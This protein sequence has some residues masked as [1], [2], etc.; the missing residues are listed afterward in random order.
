[1]KDHGVLVPTLNP[2]EATYDVALSLRDAAGLPKDKIYIL[3]SIGQ[4][5]YIG[6]AQDPAGLAT[7]AMNVMNWRNRTQTH[8]YTD[9]YFYG[10]DEKKESALTAQ[11]SA[12]QTVHANGG[13]MFVACSSDALGL[14]GDLLDVAVLYG[15]YSAQ[16]PQ[17][18]GLGERV[19]SYAN[20][21]VGV[22]N[23][24]IYRKN[25]GLALWNA[26]YDGAMDFA[27]QSKAGQS[28]WNDYDDPGWVVKDKDGNIIAHYHY[29]DHMFAYPTND[30]VIDTVQWEGWREGVDDTRYLATLISKMGSDALARSI[31]EDSLS[32]NESMSM[33]RK[34]L[35]KEI[36]SD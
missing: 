16:I 11:R 25:Y 31:V 8:G 27:Y 9:T 23:P 32:K 7:I 1:M 3:G 6:D 20:P 15:K 35:I 18:H 17:W 22:E 28:I 4:T 26:G 10:M 24:A 19:L 34:R 2:V 13:K 33:L 5:A 29:R 21:Q 30:G 14:V 12:W 36:L